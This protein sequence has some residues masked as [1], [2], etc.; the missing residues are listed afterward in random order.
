MMDYL[1]VN[2]LN[3]MVPNTVLT[4]PPVQ[5]WHD[6]HMMILGLLA[7]HCPHSIYFMEAHQ[8]VL[9]YIKQQLY[10]KETIN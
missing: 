4:G 9:K 6:W 10:R 7:V 5:T 3:G 2:Y 1:R 8:I